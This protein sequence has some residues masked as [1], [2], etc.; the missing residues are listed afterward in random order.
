MGKIIKVAEN[1]SAGIPHLRTDF[2][3]DKNGDFYV[4]EMTFTTYS[5][6]VPFEP[7][8]YDEYFGS[9]LTLPKR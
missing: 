7:Q 8:E 9:F 2:Y 1:L 5:G 4:G 6:L 3:I